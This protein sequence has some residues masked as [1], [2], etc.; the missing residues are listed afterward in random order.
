MA[1]WSPQVQSQETTDV[2]W[3]RVVLYTWVKSST[4]TY[5]PNEVPILQSL[6]RATM[7]LHGPANVTDGDIAERT[8]YSIRCTVATRLPSRVTG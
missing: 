4:R 5:D 2:L 7:S 1:F 3:L 8:R 6:N